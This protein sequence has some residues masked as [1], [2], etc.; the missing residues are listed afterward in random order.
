MANK[1][2]TCKRARKVEGTAHWRAGDSTQFRKQQSQ[3]GT[4][5]AGLQFKEPLLNG[6]QGEHS[7]FLMPTLLA[8]PHHGP[9][10]GS[11]QETDL[12]GHQRD[13]RSK[14]ACSSTAH[15]TRDEGRHSTTDTA[16]VNLVTQLSDTR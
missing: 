7:N 4:L 5:T 1:L 14:E 10:W 11:E 16:G 6:G 12:P 13:M 15:E 3:L 8:T 2:E 9:G